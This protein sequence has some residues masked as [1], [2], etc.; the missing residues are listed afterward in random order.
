LPAA[1]PPPEGG[2]APEAK[3]KKKRKPRASRDKNKDREAPKPHLQD[4][5]APLVAFGGEGGQVGESGGGE[6]YR[7][8]QG[9]V[10]QRSTGNRITLGEKRRGREPRQPREDP[11]LGEN[12]TGGELAPPLGM[13]APHWRPETGEAVDEFRGL[14][15]PQGDFG[16][17]V[18][19]E[20]PK[21]G[22]GKRSRNRKGKGSGMPSSATMLLYDGNQAETW[23]GGAATVPAEGGGWAPFEAGGRAANEA[24]PGFDGRRNSRQRGANG[25]EEMPTPGA[26]E[27]QRMFG[28]N[29]VGQGAQP[30]GGFLGQPAGR[31]RSGR[32][33]DSGRRNG[34][35]DATAPLTAKNLGQGAQPSVS[36]LEGGVDI[37]GGWEGSQAQ[38]PPPTEGREPRR[39]R[40]SEGARSGGGRYGGGK[41]AAER[42]VERRNG[43]GRGAEGGAGGEG[44]GRGKAD[45]GDWGKEASSR[46]DPPELQRGR[47]AKLERAPRLSK[48][49]DPAGRMSYC[50]KI[51]DLSE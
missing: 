6:G 7:D 27:L 26:D 29:P 3:P 5:S 24:P 46:S 13:A 44:G 35:G 32:R 12:P 9:A 41:G 15:K 17:V 28:Q 48:R 20:A 14:Q 37:E 47:R 22:S 10:T 43:G 23:Q 21:P 39:G 8:A 25:G 49:R 42:R 2:D 34:R 33:E 36:L 38:Q 50:R 19:A 16:M 30:E 1:E 31:Q 45:M 4:D 51:Y 11:S 18:D 40:R